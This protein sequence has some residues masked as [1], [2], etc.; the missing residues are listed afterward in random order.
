MSMLSFYSISK[1]LVD[2]S[3]WGFVMKFEGVAEKYLLAILNHVEPLAGNE[4]KQYEW[5]DCT[6]RVRFGDIA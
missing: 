5:L 2:R 6:C 4:V 3:E 1:Y